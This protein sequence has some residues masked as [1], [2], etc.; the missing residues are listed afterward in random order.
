MQDVR[1]VYVFKSS[2]DL[3]R[4]QEIEGQPKVRKVDMASIE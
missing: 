3:F 1:A 4:V 2:Q